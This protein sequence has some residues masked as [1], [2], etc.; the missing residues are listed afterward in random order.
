[1]EKKIILLVEDNPDDELLTIRALKKNNI[2]NEVVIVRDGV[3]AL[4]F[5]FGTGAYED[6]DMNVM[7]EVILL[8]LKLPKIEGL[9]VLKRIRDEER[10]KLLHVIIFTSSKEEQELVGSYELGPISFVRKPIDFAQFSEAVRQLGLY[11]MVL[12]EVNFSDKTK[13][14]PVGTVE[15]IPADDD[16]PLANISHISKSD[17]AYDTS[18][19]NTRLSDLLSSMS[20]E[21]IQD[22][23]EELEERL[24][25]EFR[26]KRE[27]TRKSTLIYVDCTDK[28]STFTDFIQN[29]SAG[30]LF[31]ETNIP[32]FINQ[33]LSMTFTLPNT[34]DPLEIKGKVVRSDSKGIA[35]KF[36]EPLPNV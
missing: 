2:M 10:T 5:L 21:E 3:E 13:A 31:I 22:L 8:D 35:V 27:H 26:E 19:V 11:W 9:E 17:K 14:E 30:G 28:K 6:R 20:E 32:S 29:I 36:D 18:V 15:V 12:S 7:P 23:I 33:E 25:F 4:D 34:E 24:D 16:A 1:M